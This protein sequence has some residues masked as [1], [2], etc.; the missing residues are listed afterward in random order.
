[1]NSRVSVLRYHRASWENEF[2]WSLRW[3]GLTSKYKL[4]HY[5]AFAI[6][7][8][9]AAYGIAM[10]VDVEKEKKRRA[11]WLNITKNKLFKNQTTTSSPDMLIIQKNSSLREKWMSLKESQ[12]TMIGIVGLNSLVMIA[13]RVPGLEKFMRR[14]F[15]HSIN[16]HPI[17][18]LTS[19]FSHRAPL[20]FGFNMLA[21]WSFGQLL[22]DRFGREHFLAFYLTSGLAASMGSHAYKLWRS[23]YASSLGASG[24]LFGV[25]GACAHIP[26]IKISLIFLPFQS[27]PLEHA[28]PV[29]MAFDLY[30]LI[31]GWKT[32]DH[33]AHLSGALF[34]YGFY[35]ISSKKIWANRRTILERLHYPVR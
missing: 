23:D 2:K 10:V 29:I 1:M 34:G 17:T 35:S 8:S 13:W 6:G 22:H 21:L 4:S 27:F 9:L 19:T 15:L 16:S 3:Q 5:F 20:H 32:F 24:A 33:A 31:R 18:M 28:L 11:A 12:R 7:T 26:N 25:A 14:Y 30:G